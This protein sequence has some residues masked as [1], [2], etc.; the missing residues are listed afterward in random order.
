MIALIVYVL[1]VAFK[2][3]RVGMDEVRRR[4]LC[5]SHNLSMIDLIHTRFE[6]KLD[7]LETDDDV[8]KCNKMLNSVYN[9]LYINMEDMDKKIL[10]YEDI[11][12]DEEMDYLNINKY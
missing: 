7:D 8:E 1:I 4:L 12:S 6:I 3:E 11:L 10:N 9:K 2:K 5:I